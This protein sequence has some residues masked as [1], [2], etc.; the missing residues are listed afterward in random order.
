MEFNNKTKEGI[1]QS[2]EVAKSKDGNIYISITNT[3]NGIS[4]FGFIE[5]KEWAEQVKLQKKI[6]DLM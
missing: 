1:L 2:L 6:T 3:Y 5:I 4:T